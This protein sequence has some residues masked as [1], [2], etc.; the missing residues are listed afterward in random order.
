MFAEQAYEGLLAGPAKDAD[1]RTLAPGSPTAAVHPRGTRGPTRTTCRTCR[2]RPGRPP[3]DHPLTTSGAGHG[4]NPQQHGSGLTGACEL[5]DAHSEGQGPDGTSP[6]AS[7][8]RGLDVPQPGASLLGPGD[9][10]R[11]PGS[12]LLRGSPPEG[13]ESVL[14][15]PLEA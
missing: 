10:A 3:T 6:A 11:S 13:H 12:R 5:S 8:A 14:G 1:A 7:T 4:G 15:A 9:P 2:G